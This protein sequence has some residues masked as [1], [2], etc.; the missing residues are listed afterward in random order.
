MNK[1]GISKY[2]NVINKIKLVQLKG[3][4]YHTT[5]Q[6]NVKILSYSYYE[7]SKQITIIIESDSIQ[8]IYCYDFELDEQLAKFTEKKTPKETFF[9]ESEIEINLGEQKAWENKIQ[10]K[11]QQVL[12][13]QNEAVFERSIPKTPI[14]KRNFKPQRFTPSIYSL[15]IAIMADDKKNNIESLREHLFS[16]IRKLEK[17]EMKGDDASSM[18]SL[19]QVI[20]NSA[21]L[22]LD[23]KKMSDKLP[24]IKMLNES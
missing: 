11:V 7:F 6:K 20:I 2:D 23:Y 22:Q 5:Y 14:P 21:K 16:A 4:C 8:S 9:D 12:I 10:Q 13:K 15:H 1:T 24:N 18:A 17:G 3:I 19:A